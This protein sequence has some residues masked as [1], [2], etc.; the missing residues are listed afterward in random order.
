MGGCLYWRRL[1]ASGRGSR[2]CSPTSGA[3][4]LPFPGMTAR[5]RSEHLVCASASTMMRKLS[6]A[7][8]ASSLAR[9][10][11]SLT[12]RS[13]PDDEAC[14]GA[15]FKRRGWKGSTEDDWADRK[16]ANGEAIRSTKRAR[17]GHGMPAESP[18]GAGGLAAN[19][20]ARRARAMRTTSGQ[21]GAPALRATSTN[22]Q[23][24]GELELGD[25]KSK[26]GGLEM[27]S[28]CQEAGNEGS[29]RVQRGKS[30]TNKGEGGY[31]FRSIFR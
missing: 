27:G 18:D 19:R 13:R 9:R 17:T 23:R 16:V 12:Q 14:N 10:S 2:R 8:I 15:D 1:A 31:G 5:A 7:S 29:V 4:I 22:S 21:D 11:G 20:V 26:S 3:E 6:V 24:L 25:D 28:W 30:V